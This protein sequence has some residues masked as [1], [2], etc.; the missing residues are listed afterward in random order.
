MVVGGLVTGGWVG[1]VGDWLLGG[2][3]V[4]DWWVGGL[5]DWITGW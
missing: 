1:D 3:V 4:T 5:I 2:W